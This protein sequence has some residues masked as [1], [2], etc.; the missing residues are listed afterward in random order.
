M[1]SKY[2]VWTDDYS[3]NSPVLNDQHKRLFEISNELY[4]A[5]TANAHKEK[6]GKIIEELYD[7]TVYHFSAEEK[8]IR[9]KGLKVTPEHL[10]QHEEFKKKVAD[11]RDK[12]KSGST[13][14]TY[15]IMNFVRNWMIDH[16]MGTDK[17]YA[18]AFQ[19]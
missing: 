5:F 7:Y 17:Q 19:S 14:V 18:H 4:D 6:L 11:F 10:I 2:F 13:G 3:V 8:M 15:E 16:I 1:S 9:E 12:Y